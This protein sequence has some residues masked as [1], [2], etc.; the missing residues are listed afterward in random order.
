M[1]LAINIS[2]ERFAREYQEQRPLLMKGAASSDP[3]FSWQDVNALL[4]RSG[5]F[6]D[7]FKLLL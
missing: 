2:P 3:V 7:D 4:E 6:S 1:S 5:P